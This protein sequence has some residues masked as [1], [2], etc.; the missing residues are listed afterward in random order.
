MNPMPPAAIAVIASAIDEYRLTTPPTETTP[1][2]QAERIAEHLLSSGWAIQPQPDQ[3]T[4]VHPVP[5]RPRAIREET[6]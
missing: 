2:G 1:A 3:T 4:A 6:P 5:R